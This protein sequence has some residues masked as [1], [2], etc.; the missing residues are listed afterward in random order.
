MSTAISAFVSGNDLRERQRVDAHI[1][2]L[3]REVGL[4]I[5]DVCSTGQFQTFLG[6]N[7]RHSIPPLWFTCPD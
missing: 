5:A 1:V 3:A 6:A 7:A 2:N 4:I